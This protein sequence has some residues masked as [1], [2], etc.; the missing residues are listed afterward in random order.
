MQIGKDV[1]TEKLIRIILKRKFLSL[2][3][4]NSSHFPTSIQQKLVYIGY[5]LV[6]TAMP[7]ISVVAEHG[8]ENQIRSLTDRSA[9]FSNAPDIHF[10]MNLSQSG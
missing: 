7:R 6:L 2:L 8:L 10:N 9:L 4:K 1:G 3:S 5:G